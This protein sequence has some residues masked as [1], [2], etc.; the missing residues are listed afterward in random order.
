MLIMEYIIRR[1]R[2][3]PCTRERQ[4][5]NIGNNIVEKRYVHVYDSTIFEKRGSRDEQADLER[6]EL[7]RAYING[8]IRFGEVRKTI[9]ALKIILLVE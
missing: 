6:L 7:H 5:R 4:V 9:I 8:K 1:I 2:E 3:Q